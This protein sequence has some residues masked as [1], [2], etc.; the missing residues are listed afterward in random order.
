MPPTDVS[1]ASAAHAPERQL[2]E[3]EAVDSARQHLADAFSSYDARTT[4]IAYLIG[5]FWIIADRL[6]D[7]VFEGAGRPEWTARV[8]ELLEANNREVERRRAAEAETE[9]LKAENKTLTTYCTFLV[10]FGNEGC[11]VKC[12]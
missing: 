1:R 8:A 5:E 10:E 7:A 9:R 4:G 2:T 12:R 6:R 11:S 3:R